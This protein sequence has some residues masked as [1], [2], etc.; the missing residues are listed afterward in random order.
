M[1]RRGYLTVAPP[2]GGSQKT[3]TKQTE[4]WDKKRSKILKSW[5]NSLFWTAFLNLDVTF[6]CSPTH[7]RAHDP[8]FHGSTPPPPPPLLLRLHLQ[9]GNHL[10]TE[11]FP[12]W[13]C[14]YE[15][16]D[17]AGGSQ[18]RGL[19]QVF[20][21]SGTQEQISF[22]LQVI[23]RPAEQNLLLWDVWRACQFR[24]SAETGELSPPP[25]ELLC[26][27]VK[28]KKIRNQLGSGLI[29][30]ML[31]WHF[32]A[33]SCLNVTVFK[34]QW[35]AS[36]ILASETETTFY[37]SV[38]SILHQPQ[39]GVG[40]ISKSHSRRWTLCTVLL[41]TVGFQIT[42]L[43]REVGAQQEEDTEEK[44]K[45]EHNHAL[46]ANPVFSW[47]TPKRT[48]CALKRLDVTFDWK[49]LSVN[50]NHLNL[51]WQVRREQ[52]SFLLY[53]CHKYIK[54]SHK[55]WLRSAV[56]RFT[57]AKT[58]LWSFTRSREILISFVRKNTFGSKKWRP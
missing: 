52:M 13:T 21:S 47:L 33:L 18:R 6:R 10:L 35:M 12:V 30:M 48:C 1:Q 14:R 42:S 2:I 20:S 58:Q 51:L 4:W 38:T 8:V 55:V 57:S 25:T 39:K 11:L 23:N 41:R 16:Q 22:L 34:K 3:N 45:S 17:H 56:R 54:Q 24:D 28:F 50:M 44:H 5:S 49:H 15:A 37:S 43:V 40:I 7:F 31:I 26:S 32:A 19:H 9:A 53:V 46:Y 29:K 36:I 27:S